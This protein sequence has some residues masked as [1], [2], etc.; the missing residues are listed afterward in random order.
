MSVVDS[1]GED[2]GRVTAVEMPGTEV[3]PE[4]P[5]AEVEHFMATGYLRV[6]AG[7]LTARRRYVRGAD[8]AGVTTTGDDGVVTLSVSTDDSRSAG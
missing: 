1:F 5:D 3:R 7:G 6:E 2:L 8:V 4:L